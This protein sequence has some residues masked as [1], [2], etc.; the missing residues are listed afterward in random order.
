MF[1]QLETVNFLLPTPVRNWRTFVS[2]HRNDCASRVTA[3]LR[4]PM[5][6]LGRLEQKEEE[7]EVEQRRKMMEEGLELGG[8]E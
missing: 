6:H 4:G 3:K 1:F 7:E 2:F 8:K 5:E